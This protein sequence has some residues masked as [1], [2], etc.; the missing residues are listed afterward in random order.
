MS[1][2]LGQA[3]AEAAGWQDADHPGQWV[4]V[5]RPFRDGHTEPWWAL[6]VRAGPYGPARVQRAIVVTTDPEALPDLTT[7]YL[8]TNLPAPGS[9]R[10]AEEGA[11]PAAD[12]AEIVR[13]YGLRNWVEQSYQQTRGALGWS[14]YQ[15]RSDLAIRRHW[16]LVCCAFSFCWYH[17]SRA[18]D[19]SGGATEGAEQP[20]DA[21]SP[22]TEEEAGRKK[23]QRPTAG[24]AAAVVAG[25]AAPGASVAGAVDHAVALLA[26]VVERAPAS[27]AP[28]AA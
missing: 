25:G 3:Q 20:A 12:L 21:P 13:L 11:L 7:W 2:K 27:G 17:Q 18:P 23:N 24:P 28:A 10:A 6:E 9:I 1:T 16:H 4:R 22:V 8:V 15:V 19:G 14:Q 5:E 26:R